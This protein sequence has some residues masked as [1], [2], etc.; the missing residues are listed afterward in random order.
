MARKGGRESE[1]G[2]EQIEG[3]F[4]VRVVQLRDYRDFASSQSP[5]YR[6]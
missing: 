4:H 6:P 5:N 2:C 1:A 3:P